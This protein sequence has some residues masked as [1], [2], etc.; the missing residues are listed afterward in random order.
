MQFTFNY[1]IQCSANFYAYE[2]Y[3]I[4]LFG[5]GSVFLY[6][7]FQFS[8]LTYSQSPIDWPVLMPSWNRYLEQVPESVYTTHSSSL[9]LQVRDFYKL[10]IILCPVPNS[11]D[12]IK[13]SV[14]KRTLH[15]RS[16]SLHSR[17]VLL[18]YRHSLDS[19]LGMTDSSTASLIPI[20][21]SSSISQHPP[22][23]QIT[24]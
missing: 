18:C 15:L 14:G 2:L 21:Y 4:L 12:L 20:D 8:F 11:Q 23:W 5:E 24:G 17:F 3:D 7:K 1:N 22:Q 13:L 10:S 6:L 9:H 16:S 19:L